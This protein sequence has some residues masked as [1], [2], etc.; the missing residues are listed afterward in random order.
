MLTRCF[1]YFGL[2][3]GITFAACAQTEIPVLTVQVKPTLASMYV[4]IE[5]YNSN[6]SPGGFESLKIYSIQG[7]MVADASANVQMSLS[8]P[9]IIRVETED[10]ATGAYL[11]VYRSR[12]ETIT[13]KFVRIR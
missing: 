4:E 11:V 12:N 10:Y 6:L 5:I 3:A 1:L 9:Q 2:L 8:G 13:E 7:V